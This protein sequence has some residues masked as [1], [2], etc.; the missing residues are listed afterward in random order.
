[1]NLFDFQ[2]NGADGSAFDLEQLRGKKVLVVNTASACGLTPQYAQLQELYLEVGKER[3]E[4]LAFPC[5]DFAG[6]EPGSISEILEFC[7][8]NFGV[9]FPIMEK[10]VVLGD[11]AHPLFVKIKEVIG[12]DVQWNFHKFLFDSNGDFVMELAPQESP[13]D[14]QLMDRIY[15]H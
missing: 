4:V 15:A 13:F 8:T 6:Q 1:M 12:K 11:K 14:A 10:I 3:L 2:W 7:H 5:N 9:S